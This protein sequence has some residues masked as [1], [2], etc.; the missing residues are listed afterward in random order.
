[1]G[2]GKTVVGL[3]QQD[4]SVIVKVTGEQCQVAGVVPKPGGPW[5]GGKEEGV[6]VSLAPQ[7]VS[8]PWGR[9]DATTPSSL[10]RHLITRC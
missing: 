5:K 8:L 10:R 4:T 3:A 6:P 1:M 9:A 7:S 2:G